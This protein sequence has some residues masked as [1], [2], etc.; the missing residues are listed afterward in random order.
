MSATIIIDLNEKDKE[1]FVE[2]CKEKLISFSNS[3][4]KMVGN[5]SSPNKDEKDAAIMDASILVKICLEMEKNLN[6]DDFSMK[7]SC[8]KP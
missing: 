5:L 1:D 2:Y 8:R 3:I 6:N 7:V 4:N